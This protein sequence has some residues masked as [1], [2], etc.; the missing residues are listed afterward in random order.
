[1]PDVIL[2]VLDEVEAIPSLLAGSPAGFAP[3]VVDSGSLVLAMDTAPVTPALL[4]R[5]ITR[6]DAGDG[7]VLSLARDGG[8]WAIGIPHPDSDCL[9]GVP[10]HRARTGSAQLERL[11]AC[12][13][14]VGLL[15]TLRD[16]DAFDDARIVAREVPDSRFERAVDAVAR[17]GVL[18]DREAV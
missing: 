1:V 9:L 18:G 4:E 17:A 6:R 10:M 13:L 12:Q 8:Y 3:L 7:A 15:P 5:A 16:V 11:R 2:P 14:T